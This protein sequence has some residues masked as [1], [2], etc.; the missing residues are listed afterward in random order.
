MSLTPSS[1]L[2]RGALVVLAMFAFYSTAFAQARFQDDP[3][4]SRVPNP[5]DIINLTSCQSVMEGFLPFSGFC[6]DRIETGAEYPYTFPYAAGDVVKC[7]TTVVPSPGIVLP[8][9][10][11]VL[12]NTVT[13]TACILTKADG[14]G[15]TTFNQNLLG[16]AEA[17]RTYD[18]NGVQTSEDT[19]GPLEQTVEDIAAPAFNLVENTVALA[20]SGAAFFILMIANLLLGVAGTL[21]NWVMVKTVFEFSTLIGNSPG[22]LIAWSILRD[23]AN[24]LL[25]FGF[26]FIGIA[27]ILDLHSYPAK[28]T[29]PKLI[30]FAIL[31]NFSL[32]AAEAVVD[33]SNGLSSVLYRQA[34]TSS[35]LSGAVPADTTNVEC[36]LNY[37]LAGHIM[38]STGLSSLFSS[39]I[40]P[41]DLA[42]AATLIGLALFA[43]IGAVV[44]LAASIMLIV[45]AVTLTLLMVVAPLGFAG[46]AIP[47]LEKAAKEWWNR[48]IHQAFFAPILLLLIFVS[49]KITDTLASADTRGSLAGALSQQNSST[50]GIIMVFALVIGF[51]IMSLVAAKR[52]GAM[53]ADF[54]VKTAGNVSF[55]ATGWAGRN[56][57]GRLSGVAASG[58]RKTG[59]GKTEAGR[60]T[61]GLFDRGK[62]ASFDFRAAGLS[63]IKDVDF[64]KAQKGGLAQAQ[65]DKEKARIKYAESLEQTKREKEQTSA[66]KNQQTQE[67]ARSSQ[68]LTA[69]SQ[70][71]RQ[72]NEAWEQRRKALDSDIE[73]REQSVAKSGTDRQELEQRLAEKQAEAAALRATGSSAATTVESDAAEIQ[74]SIDLLDQ[75]RTRDEEALAALRKARDD[76]KKSFNERLAAFTKQ[77]QD[78][79]S[80]S[81]AEIERIKNEIRRYNPKERYADRLEQSPFT[82][83]TGTKTAAKIR[84]RLKETT[85][86]RQI[87]EM[88]EKLDSGGAKSHEDQEEIKKALGGVQ[89][90]VKKHDDN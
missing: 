42:G 85:T 52:F 81:E 87:R 31:M 72:T 82:G 25:L 61:A 78:E 15:W 55:G 10:P 16:T 88:N 86:E 46:M 7:S 9:P 39:S 66:L 45:R 14:S 43:T 23:L 30:I 37:G 75:N 84:A 77:E 73:K 69:I 49:L 21:F 20:L 2:I 76:E 79:K 90:E 62:A 89:D 67:R 40:R 83:K 27:M 18:A 57:A 71:R 35:C 41:T 6:G 68:A 11:G 32:F 64:G 38:Q 70:R 13:N 24:M 60:Y 48:L 4:T 29:L 44:L 58:I 65:K 5:T 74:K 80:R 51:L 63:K 3:A 28:K 19:A 50:M 36:A 1:I 17:V 53:G 34:N 47:P 26:I 33:V 56:T 59:F 8:V 12:P 22:L 54:A